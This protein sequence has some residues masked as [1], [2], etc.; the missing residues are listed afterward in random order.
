[1]DLVSKI[2]T[3]IGAVIGVG[4]AIGILI[5]VNEIRSG[6][7]NEDPR[8]TDKGV[9]K[10]VLGGAIMIAVGGVVAYVLVQLNNIR[11]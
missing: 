3:L 11:F 5:G 4:S 9:M 7:S 8:T 1:M 2:I 10:V 6:L